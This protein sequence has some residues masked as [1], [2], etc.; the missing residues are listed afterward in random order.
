V[1]TCGHLF[2]ESQGKARVKAE[3]YESTGKRSFRVVGQAPV[4]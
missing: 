4:K 3:L 1:I 2:R